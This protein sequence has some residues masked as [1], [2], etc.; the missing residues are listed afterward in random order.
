[1]PAASGAE[2]DSAASRATEKTPL[3]DDKSA[4]TSDEDASLV[5]APVQ[6]ILA[7]SRSYSWRLLVMVACTVHLLKGFVAGGG[8]DGLV[9][10]P[11]EFI[12]GELGVPGGRLQMVRAAA[13]SPWAL[14]PLTA[15][16]SDSVPIFG[17][18]KI[19][20]VVITTVLSFVGALCLGLSL[21]T[22]LLTIILSL[23]F[24]FLQVST[25]DL[26][27]EARQSEEVKHK[28][29]L[30][31]DFFT[32][33][34]LGIA[35]CQVVS[36]TLVGILIQYHGPFIPYL[37][38]LPFIALVLWPTLC[39]YLGE[40]RLPEGERCPDCRMFR[41]QPVLCGLVCFVGLLV[42]MLTV[43]LFVLANRQLLLAVICVVVLVPLGFVLLIRPEVS[44]P[45]VFYFALGILSLNVDG[46]LFYFYTD[47][48]SEYPEGPH[49]SAF[50]YTTVFGICIFGGY[51][52]GFAT[53]TELFKSWSY[54]GILWLTIMLRVPIRLLLVPVLLRY[55]VK[56]G[57]HDAAWVL[58]LLYIEN[59]IMAWQWIPKQL[60][61]AHLTSRG[62]EA[63]MIGLTA[64]TF[65][66][67]SFLSSYIGGLFLHYL[68]VRPSGKPGESEMF[69]SL[70]I[71][72]IVA[73]L[74]PTLTLAF[75]P[76]LIPSKTQTDLL[77]V[78][79]PKSA[80]HGSIVNRL[81]GQNDRS[82]SESP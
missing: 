76:V 38:A 55:N 79:Q 42:I 17:Y 24:I 65:N 36:V 71:A 14:K 43:L 1:M 80:T 70:W 6:W 52:T 39:N 19:P 31:P 74:A 2:E 68:G 4:T 8:D 73:A 37:V 60:M 45:V 33:T 10:K 57:V 40:K 29:G 81:R 49:F 53:G 18:R 23:F 58:P 22:T 13:L 62:V 59:V 48:P 72:Q 69:E 78:E 44:K 51:L 16:L 56:I 21:S 11:I 34:W 32:F 26:L 7:L 47:S 25:T 64:G 77:V 15:L 5:R 50:F 20:Y 9:G 75:I 41:L 3:V 82:G 30:G 63:T 35:I 28:S 46:A 61:T 12:L 67:S 66:L 54:Q 27:V